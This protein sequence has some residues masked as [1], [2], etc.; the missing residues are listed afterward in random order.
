M[1]RVIATSLILIGLA[2]AAGVGFVAGSTMRHFSQLSGDAAGRE[3]PSITFEAVLDGDTVVD[4]GRAIHIRGLDAPELGPWAKCWAEAALAGKAKE[5]LE[6]AL[7]SKRGWRLIDIQ[8][9]TSARFS[10]RVLDKDGF[11]I[12]DELRVNGTSAMTAKHWDWCG[13]DA[14]WHDVREGEKPPMGPQLW[15]PTGRMFDPRAAD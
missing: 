4:H 12:V 13:S 10:G 8:Q 14:D 15:W 11:D 5:A 9:D 6:S 1:K 7:L 2:T 3:V